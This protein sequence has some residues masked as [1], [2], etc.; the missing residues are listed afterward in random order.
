MLSEIFKAQ[1]QIREDLK[2][3]LQKLR[4]EKVRH[5][6]LEDVE[7]QT[8][9]QYQRFEENHSK[10]KAAKEEK[11]EAYIKCYNET[12][13]IMK[14]IKTIIKKIREEKSANK[15]HME[16]ESYSTAT[17][18]KVINFYVKIKQ[19]KELMTYVCTNI[20]DISFELEDFKLEIMRY[21]DSIE[22]ILMS[23]IDEYV[24]QECVVS[25]RELTMEY[26][27]CMAKI[28]EE[29]QRLERQG[30]VAAKL[31]KSYGKKPFSV[32]GFT[33][34]ASAR[35]N[36]DDDKAKEVIN[37]RPSCL[38]ATNKNGNNIL[39]TKIEEGS[40]DYKNKQRIAVRKSPQ[41]G[42]IFSIV[43]NEEEIAVE[44]SNMHKDMFRA[45]SAEDDLEQD[46]SQ[47]GEK[48]PLF[49]DK[50]LASAMQS[51]STSINKNQQQEVLQ[52][53]ESQPSAEVVKLEAVN[54]QK[55]KILQCPDDQQQIF[56][57]EFTTLIENT[58]TENQNLKI[59]SI[60]QQLAEPEENAPK[61]VA[62]ESPRKI[63]SQCTEL[64]AMFE[65]VLHCKPISE[66]VVQ[67]D[68]KAPPWE[69]PHFEGRKRSSKTTA[70][71][72]FD[73]STID[74]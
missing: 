46:V 69:V 48:Y 16:M 34:L 58:L 55:K 40:N 27:H 42:E 52:I 49:E 53:G 37:T 14:E 71:A 11:V 72:P 41:D 64:F 18:Q 54:H 47:L 66:K 20:K 17:K 44:K 26:V 70:I 59:I 22:Y 67:K 38:P 31:T 29:L 15:G 73:D 43:E 24:Y 3:I 62:T 57:S 12:I 9:K 65:K 21:R 28:I 7:Q 1:E 61:E 36:H 23:L 10:L 32:P 2:K 39:A 51:A 25:E 74:Q 6:A 56:K 13:Y 60:Q 68:D 50:S 30:S 5:V 19:T 8:T 33:T 45:S 35:R 63:S 4:D